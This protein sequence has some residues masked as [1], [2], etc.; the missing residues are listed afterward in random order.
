M[1]VLESASLRACAH[2]RDALAISFRRLHCVPSGVRVGLVYPLRIIFVLATQ[3]DWVA[4]YR[5]CVA[6]ERANRTILRKLP[7]TNTGAC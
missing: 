1:H 3:R 6:K 4:R 7:A 5:H 2:I